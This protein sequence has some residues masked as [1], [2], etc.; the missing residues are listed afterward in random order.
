M[1]VKQLRLEESRL[2]LDQRY[3]VIH[4][5]CDNYILKIMFTFQICLKFPIN[6]T[7]VL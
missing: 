3:E 5:V 1:C 2:T 6:V 4:K 7:D